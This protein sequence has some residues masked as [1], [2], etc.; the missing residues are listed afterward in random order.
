LLAQIALGVLVSAG[1]SGLS[2][3]GFPGCGHD[4]D[5]SLALL[6][7]TRIPAFDATPPIHPQGAFAHLLHRV[8]GL[9]VALT[10][11]L[12]AVGSWRRGQRTLAILLVALLTLQIA[13]GSILVLAALPLPAAVAHNLVAALLLAAASEH[14]R[15]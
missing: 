14:L 5:A 13:L 8:L 3:T 1:Y 15:R 7:P 4:F 9:A 6:D 11:L 2:C 10:A 12:V